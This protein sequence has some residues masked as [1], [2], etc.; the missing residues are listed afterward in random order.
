MPGKVKDVRFKPH[1]L[2]IERSIV[3][4]NETEILAPDRYRGSWSHFVVRLTAGMELGEI[5]HAGTCDR[6]VDVSVAHRE[7]ST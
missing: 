2:P 7:C 4:R 6:C 1:T 3:F 5:W